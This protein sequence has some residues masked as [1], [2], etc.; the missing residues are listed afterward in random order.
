MLTPGQ[1]IVIMVTSNNHYK[2]FTFLLLRNISDIDRKIF[3]NKLSSNI[4]TLLMLTQMSR[5][6]QVLRDGGGVKCFDAQKWEETIKLT[7]LF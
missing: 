1:W 7:K 6:K 5:G 4:P 3:T 2:Y